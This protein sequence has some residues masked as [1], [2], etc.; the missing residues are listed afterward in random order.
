[1]LKVNTQQFKMSAILPISRR[2]R[3]DMFYNVNKLNE[4]FSAISYNMDSITVDNTGL[5]LQDFTH[6][7]V[8]SA[9]LTFDGHP[10]QV[11]QYSIFKFTVSSSRYAN[12]RTPIEID[13]EENPDINEHIHLSFYIHVL[14][15]RG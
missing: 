15:S 2:Y 14:Q 5:S 12:G 9:H 6:D 3:A 1:M 8:V 13:I 11:G 10:L 4:K 7:Y